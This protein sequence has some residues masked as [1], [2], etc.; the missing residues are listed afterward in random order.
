MSI[1]CGHWEP[2]RNVRPPPG[3]GRP[4]DPP[5]GSRNHLGLVSAGSRQPPVWAPTCCRYGLF[6]CPNN[7]RGQSAA[8]R[9]EAHAGLVKISVG[10][11]SC[12]PGLDPP[13]TLWVASWRRCG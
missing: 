13:H 1:R 5:R 6:T 8:V 7:P 4:D 9:T 2:L 11:L 10:A 12:P 3:E